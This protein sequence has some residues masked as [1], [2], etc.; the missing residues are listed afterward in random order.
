MEVFWRHGYEGTAI[1]DLTAAMR[2]NAPSLYAAFGCKEA[3]FREAVSLFAESEGE[4]TNRALSMERTARESVEAMLRLRA[5]AYTAPDTPRGCMIVL[6][7][8]ACTQEN[9]RVRRYCADHRRSVQEAIHAR[10]RRAMIDGDLPAATDASALAAFY[11]T[12]LQ[13]LSI[14]ARDGAARARLHAIV[15]CA[16]AAWG[17]R[18]RPH[19]QSRQPREFKRSRKKPRNLARR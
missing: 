15:D 6:S 5:D 17:M 3:L 19:A 7:A 11:T 13:G 4:A 8:V 18:V 1:S 2:V 12:V 10:L 9:E 16:M 14:Q